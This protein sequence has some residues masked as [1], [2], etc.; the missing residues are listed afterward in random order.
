MVGRK[1]LFLWGFVL[2][3]LGSA[4]AGATPS[5]PWLIAFRCL[6]GVGGAALAG[7]GTP[8]ITEAFPPA[9]LGLA[10]G[11]N[12]IAWVLGSLVGPVAGGLLVSVWGWRSVF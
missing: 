10:L 1:V 7:L 6:Q 9:E 4:L 8:I 11:I 12:S 3:A 5:G 2:F